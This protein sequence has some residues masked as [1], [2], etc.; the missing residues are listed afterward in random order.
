[1]E[2]PQFGIIAPI[3]SIS[4]FGLCI[5]IDKV[6]SLLYKPLIQ[7]IENKLSKIAVLKKY[8]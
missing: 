3:V 2:S 4:V 6:L 5:V 1:M 7:Y 8:F